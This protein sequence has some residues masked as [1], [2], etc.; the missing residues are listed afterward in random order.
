MDRNLYY[1]L[2]SGYLSHYEIEC[3]YHLTSRQVRENALDV[4]LIKQGRL[5]SIREHITDLKKCLSSDSSDP[6]Q[7][8]EC[9]YEAV[10]LGIILIYYTSLPEIERDDIRAVVSIDA[11]R[12][13]LAYELLS[14]ADCHDL[15]LIARMYNLIEKIRAISAARRYQ[16]HWVD[17]DGDEIDIDDV[18]SMDFEFPRD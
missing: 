8:S 7:I 17:D 10:D 14:M 9:I 16:E 1:D 11:H 4:Y 13:V 12:M 5:E 15:V 6:E 18:E 3:A 2:Y